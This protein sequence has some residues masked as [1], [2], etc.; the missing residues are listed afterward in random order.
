MHSKRIIACL[1]NAFESSLFFKMPK[2]GVASSSSIEKVQESPFSLKDL[3]KSS[4]P[5]GIPRCKKSSEKLPSKKKTRSAPANKKLKRKKKTSRQVSTTSLSR[6]SQKSLALSTTSSIHAPPTIPRDSTHSATSLAKIDS[7]DLHLPSS[8]KGRSSGSILQTLRRYDRPLQSVT[9]TS[10]STNSLSSS[11]DASKKILFQSPSSS[12]SVSTAS[13]NSHSTTTSVKLSRNYSSVPTNKG[14]A[15]RSTRRSLFCLRRE[16]G[17]TSSPSSRESY[18]IHE[19]ARGLKLAKFK[20][21][22]IMSGAGIS[23][24]SGI[25]DFRYNSNE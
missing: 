1:R 23:T 25:P 7:P 14:G 21:I 22:V 18:G 3:P 20:K 15:S 17:T 11:S 5:R 24:A 6:T 16:S 8:S 19:L 10:P 12:S 2:G 9:T 13:L 4:Y